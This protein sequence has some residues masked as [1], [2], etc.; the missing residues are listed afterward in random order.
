[1]PASSPH[2][3]SHISAFGET[4]A[5]RLPSHISAF[6]ESS[7]GD[8]GDLQPYVDG[9]DLEMDLHSQGGCGQPT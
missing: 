4:A 3:P 9:L 8:L 5:E 2:L 7:R 1:M 6:G